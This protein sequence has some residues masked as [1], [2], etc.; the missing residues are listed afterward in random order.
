M[1]MTMMMDGCTCKEQHYTKFLC[2]SYLSSLVIEPVLSS[3]NSTPG[4]HTAPA[5]L[6]ALEA[7]FN[8]IHTSNHCP[9]GTPLLLRRDSGHRNEAPCPRT[10]R[11]KAA[12]ETSRSRLAGSVGTVPRRPACIRSI[13]SYIWTLGVLPGSLSVLVRPA[14]LV[15]PIRC[16]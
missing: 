2:A 13:H 9:L 15:R 8:V 6:S 7:I 14:V 11:H 16:R 1:M 3:S 5:G 4:S 10:Q 12:A